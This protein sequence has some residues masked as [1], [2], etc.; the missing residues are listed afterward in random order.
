M[1]ESVYPS[2]SASLH[3]FGISQPGNR[4]YYDH[5]HAY[6]VHSHGPIIDDYSRPPENP[7]MMVS[8]PTSVMNEEWEGNEDIHTHS[9]P[10]ECKLRFPFSCCLWGW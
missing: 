1:Q 7:S 9:N 6:E 5:S 4:V 3:K 2:T 8:A 10:V